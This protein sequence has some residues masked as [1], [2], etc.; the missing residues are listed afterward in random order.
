AGMIAFHFRVTPSDVVSSIIDFE[1]SSSSRIS[2]GLRSTSKL[3]RPQVRPPA[4]VLPP[5]E[6]TPAIPV[7]VLPP[8]PAVPPVVPPVPAL[9]SGGLPPLPVVGALV[10]AVQAPARQA[11]ASS[12]LNGRSVSSTG[13]PSWARE[14]PGRG[15]EAQRGGGG[16]L[17]PNVGFRPRKEPSGPRRATDG[18]AHDHVPRRRRRLALDR[19]GPLPLAD[20]QP[21]VPGHDH[22][23][24]R[25]AGPRSDQGDARHRA[26]L[27]QRAVR[28]GELGV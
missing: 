26:R 14:C 11:A 18:E 7:T 8:A 24:H 25:P 15:A 2:A 4:P 10:P 5:I 22:Q 28:A 27:D 6:M 23:L 13:E 19:R 1:R 17:R 20:L 12:N 16:F 9:P 3:C 21:A